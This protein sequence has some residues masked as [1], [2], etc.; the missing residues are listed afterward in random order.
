[1]KHK[2]QQGESETQDV[3]DCVSRPVAF[4]DRFGNRARRG[5]EKPNDRYIEHRM[6]G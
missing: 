5:N 1:M 3:N 4:H 6:K 2:Q